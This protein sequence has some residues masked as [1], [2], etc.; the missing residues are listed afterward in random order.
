LALRA[1]GLTA[2]P[3]HVVASIAAADGISRK[4]LADIF[5]IDGK[6]LTRTLS[7]LRR[8]GWIRADVSADRR[9][10]RQGFTREGNRQ[11][12]HA[13]P[14]T[15]RRGSERLAESHGIT[16][17]ESMEATLRIAELSA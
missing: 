5:A 13:T 1:D 3:I 2:T 11:L 17:L 12:A 7:L 4:R 15:L 8:K 14:P 6:T 16:R 9:Q 10:L